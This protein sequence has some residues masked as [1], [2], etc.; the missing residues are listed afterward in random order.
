MAVETYNYINGTVYNGVTYTG[1]TTLVTNNGNYVEF[2]LA[3]TGYKN[4]KLT[5]DYRATSTSFTT[6]DW[7]YST[8]G[9]ATWTDFSTLTATRNST[10]VTGNIVNLYSAN[11][12]LTNQPDVRFRVYLSGATTAANPAN[13][14]LDNVKFTGLSLS[15]RTFDLEPGQQQYLEHHQYQLAQRFDLDQLQRRRRG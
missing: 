15:S 2:D 3:T 10:F 13:T 8:N 11:S 7:Q 5:Y 4:I 14:R 6:Q 9:G 1:P 12:A